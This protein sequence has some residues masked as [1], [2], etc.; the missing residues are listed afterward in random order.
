MFCIILPTIC[1]FFFFDEFLLYF[2][3]IID[4]VGNCS[5]N[6]FVKVWFLF[7]GFPNYLFRTMVYQYRNFVNSFGLSIGNS[8][9]R[10]IKYSFT[11]LLKIME[12]D[13]KL[14]ICNCKNSDLHL[15]ESFNYRWYYDKMSKFSTIHTYSDTR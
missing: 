12:V 11:L 8:S 13:I 5:F 14:S 6:I 2:Y 1:N 3:C 10:W 9:R 7:N 4:P 15:F